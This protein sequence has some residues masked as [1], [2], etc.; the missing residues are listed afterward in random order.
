M[1]RFL[2][3]SPALLLLAASCA[4]GPPAGPRFDG[5]YAGPFIPQLGASPES[6]PR[7]DT[8]QATMVVQNGQARVDKIRGSYFS[9]QVSGNGELTMISG[10]GRQAFVTGRIANNAY[11]AQGSGVCQYDIHL[12][13]RPG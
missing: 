6:C 2:R 8:G 5:T 7:T 9:G 3:A 4:A 11:V 1:N 10:Q 13:R 12:Q